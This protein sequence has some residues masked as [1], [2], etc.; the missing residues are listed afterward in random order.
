MISKIFLLFFSLIIFAHTSVHAEDRVRNWDPFSR[1][2]VGI[3]GSELG[4]NKNQ[5]QKNRIALQGIWRIGRRAKALISKQICG[6]GSVVD[7]YVVQRIHPDR[8][9]VKSSNSGKIEVLKIYE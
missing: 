6:V 7:G 5:S 2:S 4:P 9:I 1:N 8:V 3:S